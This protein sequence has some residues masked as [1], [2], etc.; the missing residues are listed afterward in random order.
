MKALLVALNAKYIHS[1]LGVYCLYAYSRKHGI[2]GEELIYREYTI[3]QNREGIIEN[4]YCEKPDMIGFS[5]YIW[6]IGEI[7]GIAEEL[8]RLLPDV[9]IWFGGPEV[10]YN[11]EQI[12]QENPWLAGVMTGAGEKTLYELLRQYLADVGDFRHIAGLVLRDGDRIIRTAAREPMAMDE[13][14]FVYDYISGMEHRIIYY[15]T[16][17]G[18][19][20]GC[21]YCLSSV[22]RGVCF[23]SM[24]LVERELQYFLDRRVA[25]VKFVDRTFNCN[26]EHT[27]AI[28]KYIHEHDNGVTNFHFELSADILTQEE[29]DYLKRFRSGLAQ[30]EI[31]VQSTNLTTIAAIDR[32]MD[33]E[34]LRAHVLQVRQGRN[35]HQHLDLIAGLP[36]EDLESFCKSFNDVYAMEP[37]Q[38]QL[39]FL[40]VL[41]GSPLEG[42]AEE[43]GL[44]C[45]AVPPYEVLC[46]K[47]IS[48]GQLRRLKWVEDMVERYYNSMQFMATVKYL[49]PFFQDAFHF[50]DALGQYFRSQGYGQRQQSRIQNYYILLE[51]IRDTV[52]RDRDCQID[53]DAVRELLVFDLYARENLKAEPVELMTKYQRSVGK[54]RRKLFYQDDRANQK[55]L[56]GY[57]RYQWKQRMRMTYLGWF[58]YDIVSFL[59]DGEWRREKSVVLFDYA[60]RDPLNHQAVCVKV[61]WE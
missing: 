42:K 52:N 7:K 6:N 3:N 15:E 12:L 21:S 31:G 30:F 59:K 1:N 5:C 40:K 53:V 17:R 2:S 10:S 4:I 25:Q 11:A 23:R 47:W 18:C 22:D 43:Y 29:I 49:V 16:S 38:L 20:Y 19:P 24:E 37:D 56:A 57:Q 33:L 27:M 26:P 44:V 35:I 9:D 8:H 41:K 58:S 14:P 39:G 60:G 32:K 45:Q 36:W 34:K 50:Y 55:Y 61:D 28:W 46:T 51:F 13:I 48:Y 54:D